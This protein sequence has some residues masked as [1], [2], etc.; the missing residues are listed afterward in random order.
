[1]AFASI[2]EILNE[3]RQGR[4]VVLTDDESRENEGD[5]VLPAQF[6][7]PEAVTFMLSRALGY[8]CLAMTG[9]DC[10]RLNLH[11]QASVNTTTRGT[12]FTVTIDLHHK[13]GGTT[14]VSAK[15]RAQ[16]IRMVIDQSKGPDDFVRPGHVNPLRARDGGVLVR[17]GQTEGSVDLCKLAGLYPAACIIEIMKPD[18]EMARVPD[19]E[20]FCAEHDLKMCSVEQIIQYRLARESLVRRLEPRSGQRIRTE[21][22][23]F[24][25]YL[26]ESVV[27]PLPHLALTL[28]DERGEFGP[29]DIIPVRMHRRNLLGDV[30]GEIASTGDTTGSLLRESMRVIQREGRGVVVYLRTNDREGAETADLERMLQQMRRGARDVD[31]PDFTGSPVPAE[32]RQYG[33]GGQILRNLGVHKMKLLTNNPRPIPGLTA[34]GLEIAGTEPL[35]VRGGCGV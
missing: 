28:G 19:L 10:D 34:F 3:L 12:A 7:T 29:D 30:F 32:L 26:F 25:T 8:L 2:P 22:G 11:P 17:T 23:E 31:A 4:M 5:L 9:E 35:S 18:G 13:Y 21:F 16:C 33:V 6:V 24:N 15:E 20:K 14:G 27:D 1:M